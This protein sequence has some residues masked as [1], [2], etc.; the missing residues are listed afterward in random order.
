MGP[1]WSQTDMEVGRVG[2]GGGTFLL[3]GFLCDEYVCIRPLVLNG[4]R[5]RSVST[6]SF[7]R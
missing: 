3:L 7:P 6:Y 5:Y 1:S 2:G 4:H